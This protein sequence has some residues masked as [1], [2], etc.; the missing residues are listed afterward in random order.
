MLI[1]VN[2]YRSVGVHAYFNNNCEL[3]IQQHFQFLINVL[4]QFL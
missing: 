4:H 2:R 3:L 1:N